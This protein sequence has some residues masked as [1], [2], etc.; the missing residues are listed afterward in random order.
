MLWQ[1]PSPTKRP[2]VSVDVPA[3]GSYPI[4]FQS[5]KNWCEERPR[6]LQTLSSTSVPG[7]IMGKMILSTTE[8]HLRNDKNIRHSPCGFTVGKA[9]PQCLCFSRHMKLG[10]LLGLT[11]D[12]ELV[13]NDG[14]WKDRGFSW[15]GLLMGW[16]VLSVGFLGS[17]RVFLGFWEY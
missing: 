16:L 5:T 17:F 13:K 9:C 14:G 7:K 10:E 11:G 15:P 3:D 4:L 12:Q 6:E 8:R 2:G 1:D